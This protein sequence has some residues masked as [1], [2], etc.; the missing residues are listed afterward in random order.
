MF[1]A[2]AGYAQRAREGFEDGFDLVVIGAAVHGFHVDVGACAACEALEEIC[3]QLGLQI[4]DQAGAHLGFDGEGGA[5][6]EIDCGDGERFVHGHEEVSG[7]QNAALVAE[8]AV[9]GFAERDADVFDG[10]VLIDVE[11]AVAF[12]FEI[13]CAVAGEQLQHVIEE[14]NAGGDLVLAAGLRW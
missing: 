8:G 7:A 5:A 12:E 13:E 9:E 4:A 11:I 6:T 3:H 10:V 2:R 1:V 14:A